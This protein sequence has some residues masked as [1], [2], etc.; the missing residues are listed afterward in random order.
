MTDMLRHFHRSRGKPVKKNLKKI[1]QKDP[2]TKPTRRV[3]VLRELQDDDLSN[4]AGGA[5][6]FHELPGRPW[7]W[8]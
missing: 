2:S 7:I 5:K 4:I 3:V 1:E 6:S 8:S